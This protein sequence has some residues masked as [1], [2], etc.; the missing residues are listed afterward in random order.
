MAV[1]LTLYDLLTLKTVV[2]N[3]ASVKNLA[4]VTDHPIHD[5]S[6]ELERIAFNGQADKVVD[7]EEFNLESEIIGH[8]GHMVQYMASGTKYFWPIPHMRR[9]YELLTTEN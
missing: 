6:D 5:L 7:L 9:L 3:Y 8:T 4:Y 1:H 2:L